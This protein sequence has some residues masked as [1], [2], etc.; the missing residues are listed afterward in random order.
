MVVVLSSQAV[1]TG[2]NS[3]R[4]MT[5]SVLLSDIAEDERTKLKITI[6]H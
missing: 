4:I 3:R 1:S 5:G 6:T 2:L